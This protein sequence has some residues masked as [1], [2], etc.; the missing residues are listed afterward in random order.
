MYVEGQIPDCGY[1]RCRMCK[2]YVVRDVNVLRA[3]CNPQ[4]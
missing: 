4:I 1:R 2:V 3:F